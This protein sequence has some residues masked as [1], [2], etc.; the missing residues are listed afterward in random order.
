[1]DDNEASEFAIRYGTVTMQLERLRNAKE[2]RQI[3]NKVDALV[4]TIDTFTNCFRRFRFE[5][6]F[7]AIYQNLAQFVEEAFEVDRRVR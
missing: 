1:M 2:P 5:A 3:S 4:H 6:R 7:P